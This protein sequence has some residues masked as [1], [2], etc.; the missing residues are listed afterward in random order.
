[1]FQLINRKLM[2][3]AAHLD[4]NSLKSGL[5][6][7]TGQ[8][9][10]QKGRSAKVKDRIISET[11]F[12]ETISIDRYTPGKFHIWLLHVLLRIIS[13]IIWF[14]S[15]DMPSAREPLLKGKAQYSWPPCNNRFMS[16]PFIFQI[17][18][19]FFTKQPTLMRRSTVLRLPLQLGFPASVYLCVDS[20]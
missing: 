5:L 6:H 3:T 11:K 13:I 1:L 4:I 17:L 18:F 12:I 2:F 14:C 19:T 7:L 16:A 9:I 15:Y 20:S 8:S 10:S